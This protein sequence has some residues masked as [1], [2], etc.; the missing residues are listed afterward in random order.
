M[1]FYE[2]Q[3][4]DEQILQQQMELAAQ[5][6]ATQLPIPPAAPA[7]NPRQAAYTTPMTGGTATAEAGMPGVPLPQPQ[8]PV[9]DTVATAQPGAANDPLL[10]SYNAKTAYDEALKSNDD[11]YVKKAQEEWEPY[12]KA[13]L[14]VQGFGLSENGELVPPPNYRLSSEDFNAGIDR[15]Y[16]SYIA[17]IE[18]EYQKGQQSAYDLVNEMY[19]R[20]QGN[21]GTAA[22]GDFEAGGEQYQGREAQN[23]SLRARALPL[24]QKAGF[25][26]LLVNSLQASYSMGK[27]GVE[28]LADVL[29]NDPTFKALAEFPTTQAVL[30]P[31]ESLFE[32]ADPYLKKGYDVL[33]KGISAGIDAN[34]QMG[35]STVGPSPYVGPSKEVRKQIGDSVAPWV[36]PLPADTS[37]LQL[38]TTAPDLVGAG[39]ALKPGAKV[40]LQLL[41]SPQLRDSIMRLITEETGALNIS[42]AIP[43][44]VF[45]HIEARNA[46]KQ[47]LEQ[48]AK[49]AKLAGTWNDKEL[50]QLGLGSLEE[51]TTLKKGDVIV[52]SDPTSSVQLMGR[53]SAIKGGNYHV[54]FGDP[55]RGLRAFTP[56][57]LK[58]Y[59]A[60]K[61]PVEV[62]DEEIDR[63][64]THMLAP[65]EPLPP[66]RGLPE[67]NTDMLSTEE[68]RT[69]LSSGKAGDYLAHMRPIL[70][71]QFSDVE[72]AAQ[73]M[74]TLFKNHLEE[75][76][77]N[78]EIPLPK[79]WDVLDA[80][81]AEREAAKLLGKKATVGYEQDTVNN[82]IN[83]LRTR[84]RAMGYSDQEIKILEDQVR[85]QAKL[86]AAKKADTA[87]ANVLEREAEQTTRMENLLRRSRGEDPV[88]EMLTDDDPFAGMNVQP[89]KPKV[90]LPPVQLTGEVIPI[91]GKTGVEQ[92][93]AQALADIDSG[94]AVSRPKLEAL[95]R[96]AGIT[97]N[98][99]A[100]TSSTLRPED[101]AR[102]G[103]EATGPSS[104]AVTAADIIDALR[105]G[106]NPN[107]AMTAAADAQKSLRQQVNRLNSEV[108][109]LKRNTGKGIVAKRREAQK[110]L[111][112]LKAELKIADE[113]VKELTTRPPKEPTSTS[114]T[115]SDPPAT[116]LSSREREIQKRFEERGF[117]ARPFD[118][119]MNY[120]AGMRQINIG[121]G[122]KAL[123]L[124]RKTGSN[125][126]TDEALHKAASKAL[127]EELHLGAVREATQSA[128]NRAAAPYSGPNGI[129]RSRKIYSEILDRLNIGEI[130]Q[131]PAARER[132]MPLL[133]QAI[134][135]RAANGEDVEDLQRMMDIFNQQGVEPKTPYQQFVEDMQSGKNPVVPNPRNSA[136][137]PHFDVDFGRP[138]I[139]DALAIEATKGQQMDD[140]IRGIFSNLPE[141]IRKYVNPK[142]A[143][144]FV[145]KRLEEGQLVMDDAKR[146]FP[147]IMDDETKTI[148]DAGID[149]TNKGID[150][151]F[152]DEFTAAWKKGIRTNRPEF[153]PEAVR[154]EIQNTPLVVERRPNGRTRVR[155]ARQPDPTKAIKQAIDDD[156]VT[157]A[158]TRLRR[159]IKERSDADRMNEL[160]ERSKQGLPS[161]KKELGK[162]LDERADEINLEEAVRE[163]EDANKLPKGSADRVA[164]GPVEAPPA[165]D[166]S[167]SA[168]LKKID[169]HENF[170]LAD[171]RRAIGGDP[172][173]LHRKGAKELVGM[174][175]AKVAADG[176]PASKPRPNR[177][178]RR[179]GGGGQKPPNKPPV[180]RRPAWADFPEGEGFPYG[181][182]PIRP[183]AVAPQPARGGGVVGP[184]QN[185]MRPPAWLD[186]TPGP[187]Q[188]NLPG[189]EGPPNLGG[190]VGGWTKPGALPVEDTPFPTGGREQ[191]DLPGML[192]HGQQNLRAP[193]AAP[194]PMAPGGV[195]GTPPR[196]PPTGG[197]G[198]G[199]MGPL[200]DFYNPSAYA[201]L[202]AHLNEAIQ[203]SK[204][205][206]IP[207]DVANNI[208]NAMREALATADFSGTFRQALIQSV[209]HPFIAAGTLKKQVLINWKTVFNDE[210]AVRGYFDEIAK[211]SDFYHM[212]QGGKIKLAVSSADE[213]T[214]ELSARA[215]N[216]QAGINV[217]EGIPS[218]FLEKTPLGI[219]KALRGNRYAYNYA[220]AKI[221]QDVFDSVMRNWERNQFQS[222][223]GFGV[224]KPGF[225][226]G[227]SQDVSKALGALRNGG[228]IASFDS[229]SLR[230]ALQQ[231]RNETWTILQGE[232]KAAKAAQGVINRAERLLSNRGLGK[233][234]IHTTT[235][236]SPEVQ[237]LI[238]WINVSTGAGDIP[239]I[240][241]NPKG[242]QALTNILFAPRLWFS[243]IQTPLMI[244][245]ALTPGGAIPGRVRYQ[246][247]RD[248]VQSISS[249][250][251]ILGLM[252]MGGIGSINRD[253]TSSDFL[254]LR[255][256]N[257]RIDPWGGF[258]QMVKLAVWPT[259]FAINAAKGDGFATRTATSGQKTRMDMT[260]V[261]NGFYQYLGYKLA[262][263]PSMVGD[264]AFK[265]AGNNRLPSG[266]LASNFELNPKDKDFWQSTVLSRTVPLFMQDF[267]A[268]MKAQG[269]LAPWDVRGLDDTMPYLKGA[270]LGLP[271]FVGIG[272]SS[273]Q[274]PT[275]KIDQIIK[276]LNMATPA[277]VNGSAIPLKHWWQLDPFQKLQLKKDHP[278]IQKVL[279]DM[280]PNEV[281]KI[282]QDRENEINQAFLDY[283]HQG[284]PERLK[285]TLDSVR[286]KYAEEFAKLGFEGALNP[287]PWMEKVNGFFDGLSALTLPEDKDAFEASFRKNLSPDEQKRLDEILQSSS[288]PMYQAY[289]QSQA[290]LGEGYWDQRARI[291]ENLANRRIPNVGPNEAAKW[292][293]WSNYDDLL[294]AAATRGHP[295]H[296]E[297]LEF[298]NDKRSQL[299]EDM[300]E[301]LKMIPILDATRYMWGY[302]DNVK[303]KDALIWAQMLGQGWGVEWTIAPKVSP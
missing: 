156:A 207:L 217:N 76:L 227:K 150:K 60:H 247:A 236:D 214:T 144:N 186:A 78:E 253:P 184:N 32:P 130:L 57:E 278:E 81:K 162:F 173:E 20:A 229:P 117:G 106:P 34:L 52:F 249:I 158:P 72:P 27:A 138:A 115:V 260:D 77:R 252:E 63:A 37:P 176:L 85:Q 75:L 124:P 291:W 167:A 45:T 1:N 234:D 110:K 191:L 215:F 140:L 298:M 142:F 289:K 43:E 243:R 94:K 216:S 270:A 175:R 25:G 180:D 109:R 71:R 272:S 153:N 302:A 181:K 189:I 290:L 277:D 17:E 268:A 244:G 114:V 151:A 241:N 266:A 93:I 47:L 10:I 259:Q 159:Q 80:A 21:P 102:L 19:Q 5:R 292:Q 235:A 265:A 100:R 296:K 11:R 206:N 69:L 287:S 284:N 135:T 101:A 274:T 133:Q 127:M 246:I 242:I 90:E 59:S 116:S 194:F 219:G 293:K 245:N 202:N 97:V 279:D 55:E 4:T 258:Q 269:A 223:G 221:R 46:Y 179:A 211:N 141:E 220:L 95:A 240:F 213:I 36:N 157:P 231:Y 154:A 53:I 91:P 288:I 299:D 122:K 187:G 185:M 8:V 257:T 261:I 208:T 218:S 132:A 112:D 177:A 49:R 56:S 104:R 44:N 107:D 163:W 86:N 31:N 281:G 108:S 192:P 224:T 239:G 64:F 13:N 160:L 89:Q 148:L 204:Q 155:T 113:R 276:G 248:T 165:A 121:M 199:Q 188:P 286:G 200:G 7:I 131:E 174:L 39:L 143:E 96:E 3:L 256:G 82:A 128:L 22:L 137:P 41:Q 255:I 178:Q 237:A 183:E 79:S 225:L 103:V 250:L 70:A 129:E 166:N 33:N 300:A 228:D 42:K 222:V 99:P 149:I 15:I 18:A 26:D 40:G 145:N 54:S 232:D 65:N 28:G 193:N 280:P 273:F 210:A 146:I 164:L 297:A 48:E 197:G 251:G 285:D 123:D 29:G 205:K 267:Y 9:A 147:A 38:L 303:S 190:P 98:P 74:E 66:S 283:I 275:D 58:N 238:H 68:A 84:G 119:A 92:R 35:G 2:D 172:V 254:K 212:G 301:W 125:R 83:I 264:L 118:T 51:L 295:D 120:A 171:V 282:V 195:G 152:F 126:V 139:A 16:E 30:H 14:A 233:A 12:L 62:T 262:P 294:N 198:R 271:A 170:K 136:R 67:L 201:S 263:F 230:Q 182:E 134:N 61:M 105:R 87:N 209:V 88:D 168:L 73:Q 23:T 226:F 161:N 203:L 196:K 24:Q 169:N 111:D 50:D 6:A